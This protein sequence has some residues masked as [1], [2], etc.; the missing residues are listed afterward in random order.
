M[1]T[2]FNELNPDDTVLFVVASHP[3]LDVAAEGC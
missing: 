1:S 3:R 2:Y